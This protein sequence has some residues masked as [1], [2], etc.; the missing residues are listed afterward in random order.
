MTGDES[1]SEANSRRA[2][3]NP[4]GAKCHDHSPMFSFTPDFSLTYRWKPESSSGFSPE[5]NSAFGLM[6]RSTKT[7]PCATNALRYVMFGLL[8]HPCPFRPTGT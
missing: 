6:S 8:R 4:L 1:A 2:C 7:E 5:S 3:P